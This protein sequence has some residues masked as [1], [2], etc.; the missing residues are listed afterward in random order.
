MCI[1]IFF[2]IALLTLFLHR[3]RGLLVYACIVWESHESW[4]YR[5]I[6]LSLFFSY[7][8]FIA[9]HH[10]SLVVFVIFSSLFYLLL[11]LLHLLSNLSG[12]PPRFIK[13][14][15]SFP[16]SIPQKLIKKSL[17]WEGYLVREFLRVCLSIIDIVFEGFI[18]LCLGY[19]HLY[20]C[21]KKMKRKEK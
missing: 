15:T 17:V 18:C 11:V 3:D 6:F 9:F 19:A 5:C 21:K 10:I 16:L 20:I 12:D 4:T 2:L 1:I 8:N 14:V 7:H 13:I